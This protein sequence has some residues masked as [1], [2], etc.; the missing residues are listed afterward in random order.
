MVPLF[1]C[2]WVIRLPI[3]SI[4]LLWLLTCKSSAST[5]LEPF[6]RELQYRDM[7]LLHW[8][9]LFQVKHWA[10]VIQRRL[11]VIAFLWQIVLHTHSILHT[12]TQHG[13]CS[14]CSMRILYSS[15]RIRIFIAC[16]LRMLCAQAC[17]AFI[18]VLGSHTPALPS[19]S[20]FFRFWF[21]FPEKTWNKKNLE[22][23]WNKLF[24]W[25]GLC[26]HTFN[27]YIIFHSFFEKRKR[28]KKKNTR[29]YSHRLWSTIKLNRH[30][31][32]KRCRTR[33]LSNVRA[34]RA[35]L[36]R[37][38]LHPHTCTTPWST[39]ILVQ[40]RV[41]PLHPYITDC[42]LNIYTYTHTHPHLFGVI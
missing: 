29:E 3:E 33:T 10:K 8:K 39:R 17:S 6:W 15:T 12:H 13:A 37:F 42:I 11:A 25:E 34:P 35:Y 9:F 27:A 18:R 24:A 41:P 19:D 32:G 14:T 22:N 7:M 38:V 26:F 16:S 1:L 23:G 21:L 2:W 5:A 30:T 20:R 36:C 40:I 31:H 28:C 4:A